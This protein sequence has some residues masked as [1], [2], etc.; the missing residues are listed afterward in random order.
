MAKSSSPAADARLAFLK[1][2]ERC[3]DRWA[4][5]NLDVVRSLSR[6]SGEVLQKS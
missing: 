5:A 3:F 1:T 6:V 4:A 2:A